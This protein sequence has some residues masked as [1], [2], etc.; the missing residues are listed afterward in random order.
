MSFMDF[1]KVWFGLVRGEISPFVRDA[2]FD[3]T[4]L[5]KPQIKLKL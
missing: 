2:A 1:W 4:S 3:E 5:N